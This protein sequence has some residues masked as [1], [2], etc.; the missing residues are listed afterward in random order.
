MHVLL[1]LDVDSMVVYWQGTFG[2][3]LHARDATGHETIRQLAETRN[4][5]GTC[6]R[7]LEVD[8]NL[9]QEIIALGTRYRQD[10]ARRGILPLDAELRPKEEKRRLLYESR[11]H[12]FKEFQD[13][14][15]ELYESAG[16]CL[17]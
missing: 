1:F 17:A 12:I 11:Q 9:A 10:L 14:A 8:D 2:Y 7:E 6:Y 3:G 13:K 5:A 16:I 15:R 4:T